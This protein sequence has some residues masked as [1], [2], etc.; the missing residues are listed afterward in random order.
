[1]KRF[2]SF[3]L[4]LG[5]LLSVVGRGDA[6]LWCVDGA[7]A[8]ADFARVMVTE[9]GNRSDARQLAAFAREPSTGEWTADMD[10]GVVDLVNG[11]TGWTWADLTG[12]DK[13]AASFFIE[14]GN[15]VWDTNG[16]M[17]WTAVEASAVMRSYADLSQYVA[18]PGLGVDNLYVPWSGGP[19]AP[20]P[21]PNALVL[22]LL[23]GA[24]LALRRN[25][26]TGGVA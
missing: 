7:T 22:F 8:E 13:A 19:Y 26:K 11:G 16:E 23:G 14:L 25:R 24:S 5:G 15:A 20:V 2:S 9:T 6:L 1:M 10:L 12:V 18:L 21:E 3:L 17:S 4:I